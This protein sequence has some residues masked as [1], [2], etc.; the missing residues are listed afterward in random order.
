MYYIHSFTS[1]FFVFRDIDL[2]LYKGMQ[3][4]KKLNV[5]KIMPEHVLI[6]N[7][8]NIYLAFYTCIS[9]FFLF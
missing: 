2:C 4:G 5:M 7:E 6:K 1:K 9:F 3:V 8:K